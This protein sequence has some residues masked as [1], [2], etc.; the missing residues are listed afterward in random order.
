MSILHIHLLDD[1]QI[2]YNDRL[3][4]TVNTARLQTLLA[5]LV[6]HRHAPQAR[7][8]LAFLF[9]RDTNETQALTKLRTGMRLWQRVSPVA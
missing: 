8:P 9:W 7:Q 1:F 3:L 5:Y 6:L 2:T 4:T